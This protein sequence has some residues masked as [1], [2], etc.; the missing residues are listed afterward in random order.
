MIADFDAGA[1]V[2][3]FGFA[4]AAHLGAVASTLVTDPRAPASTWIVVPISW[5][6]G[7]LIGGWVGL[8]ASLYGGH[9]V[10]NAIDL[11]LPARA[12]L[13]TGWALG[14][15]LG[16]ACAAL[17]ATVVRSLLMRRISARPSTP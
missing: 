17:P 5:G 4:G 6:L 10:E 2:A 11:S 7:F 8:V 16:G 15:A 13:T 9:L 14:G 1:L 3:L 12:K